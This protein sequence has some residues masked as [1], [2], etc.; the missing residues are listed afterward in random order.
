M[1]HAI[2]V[3]VALM[4]GC[5]GPSV[6]PEHGASHGAGASDGATADGADRDAPDA[7]PPVSEDTD[8]CDCHLQ[9]QTPLDQCLMKA[10]KVMQTCDMPCYQTSGAI[11]QDECLDGCFRAYAE[12]EDACLH[13]F[14]GCR[15]ACDD[16]CGEATCDDETLI[17]YDVDDPICCGCLVTCWN[18]EQECMLAA[19]FKSGM[20]EKGCGTLGDEADSQCLFDCDEGYYVQQEACEDHLV[21]CEDGCMGPCEENGCARFG[22]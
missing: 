16:G 19:D 5:G 4:I 13:G 7:A 8:C 14:S 6:A 18:S 2:H 22:Y 9:C 12:L 15:D 20:C 10:E 21:K 1:R 11:A 17:P 3:V